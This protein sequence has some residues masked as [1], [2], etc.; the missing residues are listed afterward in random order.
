[1]LCAMCGR[2]TLRVP[3][4]LM[5][6]FD[7]YAGG[8]LPEE[9][10]ARFNIAPTQPL[11]VLRTPG[12]LETMP[13]STREHRA[14]NVR[15]EGAS[16]KPENRCLVVID[17]FYEWTKDKQP[18]FFHRVDDAPFFLAGVVLGGGV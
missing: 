13:W 15:V 11:T 12:K 5:G 6:D 17:G 9:L 14:V 18:F 10:V 1:M 8:G 4:S 7:I 16:T 3:V 2:A